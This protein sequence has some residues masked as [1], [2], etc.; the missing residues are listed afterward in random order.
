MVIQAYPSTWELEAGGTGAQDQ[1]QLHSKFKS[2][3]SK[4][5]KENKKEA[6][7]QITEN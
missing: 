5:T 2:T 7:V 1:S 3:L 4:K 6:G